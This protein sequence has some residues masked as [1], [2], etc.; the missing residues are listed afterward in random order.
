T[1]AQASAA[2]ELVELLE[3]RAAP[4]DDDAIVALATRWRASTRPYARRL[5]DR[6][7]AL[8]RWR[9]GDIASADRALDPLAFKGELGD[10]LAGKIV[11]DWGDPVAGAEVVTALVPPV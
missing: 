5:L 10:A 11:D 7:A 2:G 6:S 3:R 4:G 8:V 9:R 1:G